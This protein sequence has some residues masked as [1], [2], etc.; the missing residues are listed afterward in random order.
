ML[1]PS[2]KNI[3]LPI[4]TEF[5][6]EMDLMT[7]RAPG[8]RRPSLHKSLRCRH[9]PA[10]RDQPLDP[11]ILQ[12]SRRHFL[13][14]R[15]SGSIPNPWINL[16]CAGSCSGGATLSS[17][18]WR[19]HDVPLQ[20]CAT[21]M[22]SACWARTTANTRGR[23]K[24]GGLTK[25]R[26][27]CQSVWASASTPLVYGSRKKELYLLT[28]A[29]LCEANRSIVAGPNCWLM[30]WKTAGC[31]RHSYWEAWWLSWSATVLRCPGKNLAVRHMSA[32]WDRLNM[33]RSMLLRSME[34]PPMRL[35]YAHMVTLS[36]RI[37][38]LFPLRWGNM[39]WRVNHTAR[40][41]LVLECWNR[42]MF[43]LRDVA[44]RSMFLPI[45]C[46]LHPLPLALLPLSDTKEHHSTCSELP[47]T[48]INRQ[49]TPRLMSHSTTNQGE[50]PTPCRHYATAIVPGQWPVS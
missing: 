33:D 2:H 35:M 40:S 19:N 22:A 13:F 21:T 3:D 48:M 50:K 41:S 27:R 47:A 42:C 25:L 16:G 7:V 9:R 18:S 37:C 43:P 39:D 44:D 30:R 23:R 20:K 31:R 17:L 49:L 36:V 34:L 15:G 24:N 38:T 14:L 46:C 8:G 29:V 11:E 6:E 10:L 1:L 28:W 4:W 32:R 5:L 26:W 45:Q 12:A